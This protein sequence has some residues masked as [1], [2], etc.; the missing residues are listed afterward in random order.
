ME[1]R[2][3]LGVWKAAGRETQQTGKGAT[4]RVSFLA[5]SM[6]IYQRETTAI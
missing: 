2:L 4:H 3:A 5:Q 6:D 1:I